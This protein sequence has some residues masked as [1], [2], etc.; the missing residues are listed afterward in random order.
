MPD[1]SGR[2]PVELALAARRNLL[3]LAANRPV[4]LG[5]SLS[6]VDILLAGYAEIGL[7]R[8]NLDD[9]RRD[10]LI[11][12]KGHAVWAQYAVLAALGLLDLDQP[13]WPGHP[14][15]GTPGVDA[16]TGAL[17]HGLS[18]GAGLAESARLRGRNR[19]TFVILGDGELNEGSVWE[20]VMYAA[21]R[22]LGRLTAVVDLNGMQQE[23]RTA[24]VLDLQPLDAKWHAFGWRVVEVDGHD[25]A[26]LRAS[27]TGGASDECAPTVVLARTVKGKGVPFMEHSLDWHV[28]ALEPAQLQAALTALSSASTRTVAVSHG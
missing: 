20:A 13:H 19:R 17:G 7:C 1:H 8:E 11:L 3:H 5:S 18:I 12:S 28:G 16:A 9:P 26:A 14:A 23:G 2:S 25:A 22:R 6:V 27:L 24:D 10:R 4:H 21:H 15:D